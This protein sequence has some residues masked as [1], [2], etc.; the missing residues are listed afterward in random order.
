MTGGLGLPPYVEG[1]YAARSQTSISSNAMLLYHALGYDLSGEVGEHDFRFAE[2][3][4]RRSTRANN[5]QGTLRWF[6]P[7]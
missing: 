4:Y 1:R 2:I 3:F 7:T 5:A 6:D